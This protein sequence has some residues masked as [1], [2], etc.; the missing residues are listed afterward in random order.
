VPGD[1]VRS[2][3]AWPER[4]T[5]VARPTGGE[6]DALRLVDE[7]LRR[8]GGCL[9]FGLVHESER[10]A[11]ELVAPRHLACEPSERIGRAPR[12]QTHDHV[13]LVDADLSNED[14]VTEERRRERSRDAA[15]IAHERELD[16]RPRA[17]SAR[18]EDRRA[19]GVPVPVD[20]AERGRVGEPH[21]DPRRRA[22]RG[23]R[24]VDAVP[25]LRSARHDTRRVRRAEERGPREPAPLSARDERA[26]DHRGEQ[27]ARDRAKKEAASRHRSARASLVRHVRAPRLLAQCGR[28]VLAQR[29]P[30]LRE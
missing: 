28:L 24:L 27:R 5:L 6:L 15:V 4:A 29:H 26:D 22:R 12:T 25:K 9:A 13:L 8:R 18:H 3:P 14:A 1:D 20:V 11:S 7:I 10:L 23:L 21:D 30:R 2:D 16:E 17:P 19:V